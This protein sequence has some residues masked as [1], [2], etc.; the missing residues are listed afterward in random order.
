MHDC[1]S[2]LKLFDYRMCDALAKKELEEKARRVA[3]LSAQP[4]FILTEVLQY[5]AHRRIVALGY[6]RQTPGEKHL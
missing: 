1:R 3:M 2:I 6:P 4:V 5:L